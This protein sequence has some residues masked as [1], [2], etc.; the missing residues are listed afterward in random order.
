[1]VVLYEAAVG[2][3]TLHARRKA[4]RAPERTVDE[5]DD[6]I[7]ASPAMRP[8]RWPPTQPEGSYRKKTDK[9][10]RVEGPATT[11]RLRPQRKPIG[12]GQR[13]LHS[14]R[15]RPSR[16]GRLPGRIGNSTSG[17]SLCCFSRPL[18]PSTPEAQ[19]RRLS[20]MCRTQGCLGKLLPTTRWSHR[21]AMT[22]ARCLVLHRCAAR[23]HDFSR[24]PNRWCRPTAASSTRSPASPPS[25]I[26]QALGG[27]QVELCITEQTSSVIHL[28]CGT[29]RPAGRRVP[30]AGAWR[31]SRGPPIQLAA[32]GRH[33]VT[34]GTR[35]GLVPPGS[36]SMEHQAPSNVIARLS[37]IGWWTEVPQ[38]P[39]CPA[40]VH[41]RRCQS[42]GVEGAR[43]LDVGCNQRL[44]LKQPIARAIVT[45]R[46]PAVREWRRLCPLPMGCRCGRC[47]GR[48]WTFYSWALVVGGNFEWT[49]PGLV[50]ANYWVSGRVDFRASGHRGR[51]RCAR[52]LV[53]LSDGRG[54]WRSRQPLRRARP[55]G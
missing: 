42:S 48:R 29:P 49:R 33:L 50:V 52:G 15:R 44:S 47:T 37:D 39:L 8:R 53:G 32:V 51:R 14:R 3:A 30:G 38:T 17:C 41:Q 55:S 19:H 10:A 2:F 7:P 27:P 46:G 11:C 1:M 28:Q 9:G 6:R 31:R 36:A 13:R 45:S 20:P 5:R 40:R 43:R 4:R 25:S 26:T 18:A 24:V 21:R 23:R 54:G 35:E 12:N 22:L 16:G 34:F